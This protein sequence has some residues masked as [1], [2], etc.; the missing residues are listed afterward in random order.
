MKSSNPS[1]TP[2]WISKVCSEM[3]STNLIYVK[4]IK[5]VRV[6]VDFFKKFF[7]S[8][9]YWNSILSFATYYICEKTNKQNTTLDWVMAQRSGKRKNCLFLKYCCSSSKEV[10]HIMKVSNLL[11]WFLNH[12]SASGSINQTRL[13]RLQFKS[14]KHNNHGTS[15]HSMF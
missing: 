6:L 13:L 4:F 9:I 11:K 7:K 8:E 15:A 10:V 3:F 5:I 2:K 1:F 12:S 14:S